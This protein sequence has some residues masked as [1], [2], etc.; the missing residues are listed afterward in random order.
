MGKNLASALVI[1]QTGNP[2]LRFFPKGVGF[3]VDP[4]HREKAAGGLN[5]LLADRSQVGS[6]RAAAL[7]F[8]KEALNAEAQPKR[9][10]SLSLGQQRYTAPSEIRR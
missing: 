5:S 10:V 3:A 4:R 1:V 9:F 8:H 2:G 6:A 7:N